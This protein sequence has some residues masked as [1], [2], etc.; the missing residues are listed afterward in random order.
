VGAAAWP[1]GDADDGGTAVEDLADPILEG[2]AVP[3]GPAIP[4][5][6][7]TAYR[8]ASEPAPDSV[9]EDFAAMPALTP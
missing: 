8:R 4:L 1:P 2:D 6:L 9:I 5:P 3:L 7:A